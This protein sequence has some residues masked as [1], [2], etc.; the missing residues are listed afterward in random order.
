MHEIVSSCNHT[1][2]ALFSQSKIEEEELLARVCK[3]AGGA[4]ESI[5]S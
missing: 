1:A 2:M 5:L 3:P 4:Y